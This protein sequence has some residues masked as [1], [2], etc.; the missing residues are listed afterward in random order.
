MPIMIK[1]DLSLQE[2]W[3]I[4]EKVDEFFGIDSGDE[5]IFYCAECWHNAVPFKKVNK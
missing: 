1:E 2:T 4:K 5:D 3:D